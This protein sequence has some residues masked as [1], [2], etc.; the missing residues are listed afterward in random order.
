MSTETKTIWARCGSPRGISAVLLAREIEENWLSTSISAASVRF[1]GDLLNALYDLKDAAKA[2]K[3]NLPTSSLRMALQSTIVGIIYVD[4]DLGCNQK[5]PNTPAIELQTTEITDQNLCDCVASVVHSWAMN[6]LEPWAH[7]EQFGEV[8]ARVKKAAIGSNVTVSASTQYLRDP[9]TRAPN[10]NLIGRLLAEQLS[11]QE[12]FSG[13]DACEMVFPQSPSPNAFE[14]STVPAKPVH[15][16]GG[17]NLYSMIARVHISTMPFNDKVYFSMSCSKRVWASKMP[18]GSNTGDRATA[19]V[20]PPKMNG[21]DFIPVEVIKKKVN[22]V[23]TWD[24]SD[25]YAI[26]V[27]NSQGQLPA[28]LTDALQLG[29]RDPER[30]WVGLPQITR[31]YRSVDQ[32]TAMESDEVD[33]LS[34]ALPMLA[35][36]VGDEVSAIPRRLTLNKKPALTML[37]AGDVGA[38]GI[39]IAEPKEE[40]LST[41]DEND[42]ND[43]SEADSDAKV[44]RF[45]EQCVNVIQQAFLG[46]KPGLW[47]I[48][49]TE[50]E[51]NIAKKT[52]ELLFGDAIAVSI[53]PM[54]SNVHG[55]KT[56]L[57]GAELK[58]KQRF[59][60]RVDAWK[61]NGIPEAIARYP[62]HKF[63]LICAPKDIGKKPE[64]VVNRRAAIHAICSLANASVH[65]V[66][67]I[68]DAN[69]LARKKK[70]VASYIHRIQSAMMDVMLAHSGYVIGASDFVTSQMSDANAPKFICGIQA[71]R[72]Q[73]QRY[74][75]EIPVC[76]V[77]YS[78]INLS[79]NIT[80]VNYAYKVGNQTNLSGWMPLSK[81][82]IW[83][84][85][86]R[87]MD[88]D[89]D[90]LKA[91]FMV[92]TV[93]VLHDIQAQDPRAVVFIDWE[94]MMSLW[95]NLTDASLQANAP[96]IGHLALKNAFPLMSFVRL[97]YGRNAKL[98][99]RS[100]SKTAYEGFRE[101]TGRAPTGEYWDDIYAG[102]IKQ[103]L[104]V[105]TTSTQQGH[106]I[107]VM[108]PRKT[109]QLVRGSS[110]YRFM[111]RMRKIPSGASAGAGIFEK[112]RNPPI[113]KDASV[114]TSMDIT[115]LH[116]PADTSPHDIATL[117]MGLRVGYAHYDDWTLLPA[118]LFFAR[119]IDD[120]IIKYPAPELE[121]AADASL[122]ADGKEIINAR[123]PIEANMDL[124]SSESSIESNELHLVSEQIQRELRLEF[125]EA[126]I[127]NASFD[128]NIQESESLPS[129]AD[130]VST[131]DKSPT[132]DVELDDLSTSIFEDRMGVLGMAKM[133]PPQ[134]IF[135]APDQK[136]RRFYS[137]MV[138]GEIK[139]IVDP[140]YFVE[141]T[142]FFGSYHPSMKK[143]VQKA[144]K[145]MQNFG[146]V[147]PGKPRPVNDRFLDEMAKNL[148]HPQG[149]YSTTQRSFGRFL[150]MPQLNRIVEKHNKEC[151]E[152][153]SLTE[154]MNGNP[155]I[156][157]SPIIKQAC[158][159]NDDETLAWMIFG[160]AQTPSFNFRESVIDNVTTVPGN[161]TYAALVYFVQCSIALTRALLSFN[162][163]GVRKFESI[164][165]KPLFAP[166]VDT[167]DAA[168]AEHAEAI[169]E[170]DGANTST[171][172]AKSI[173]DNQPP[174]EP[175][176]DKV[177]EIKNE[178]KMV[179]DQIKPGDQTF[180]ANLEKV[181]QLIT[182][183]VDIDAKEREALETLARLAT[184]NQDLIDLANRILGRI[185]S[186][187]EECV[188]GTFEFCVPEAENYSDAQNSVTA[189]DVAVS[190]AEASSN[191][192]GEVIAQELPANS[193]KSERI[194]RA[195]Q[196]SALATALSDGL[197]H[198]KKLLDDSLYFVRQDGGSDSPKTDDA[199][200]SQQPPPES[201]ANGAEP[202]APTN[203]P[204]A[205]LLQP[206]ESFAPLPVKAQ[207]APQT[208]A[209]IAS[210]EA[211]IEI[212]LSQPQAQNQPPVQEAI[213]PAQAS[214]LAPPVTTAAVEVPSTPSPAKSSVAVQAAPVAATN[215]KTEQAALT[216]DEKKLEQAYSRL[217]DLMELRHYGLSSVY[218]EAMKA[219]FGKDNIHMQGDILLA[220]AD[221][222]ESIDCRFVVDPRLHPSLRNLFSRQVSF[223]NI[224]DSLG[225]LAA[226]F[227]SA[228]FSSTSISGE[229]DSDALWAVFGPVRPALEGL[230]AVAALIDHVANRLSKGITLTRKSSLCLKSEP[231]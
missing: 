132:E 211:D 94:T 187:D 116:T 61:T 159:Q 29:G 175:Q 76:M 150:I 190:R 3:K 65:H 86:Q 51:Q 10:L 75:G 24:F 152:K 171:P 143:S 166:T 70:A 17:T 11:G 87:A 27:Q 90:W 104:E 52:A 230:P 162:K 225:V 155:Y 170:I 102:T 176:L 48:G 183:L 139:V 223:S 161:M 12:L 146:Y 13:L 135:P 177:M 45:R 195:Q 112:V 40:D 110:C 72:R 126:P 103:L 7:R 108:G 200:E 26:L 30:W 59:S 151:D 191:K 121:A 144:W 137:A 113:D 154:R 196:V 224:S 97:R 38:A 130:E 41:A 156:D 122:G 164:H 179:I 128:E 140:P 141:L 220:L 194:K 186:I 142:G 79:T 20:L 209:P 4:K 216:P 32:H 221:T 53:D 58:S 160:A 210:E 2:S 80:E 107:G 213:A 55:L 227:V 229:S 68:E 114:P 199:E 35:G 157:F 115:V 136:L 212:E 123:V 208:T 148:R 217:K 184:K 206:E 174:N 62:G 201:S 23:W 84:G 21:G 180:A 18:N 49:G 91:E 19:Y 9:E 36:Q 5:Y 185:N 42:E 203:E 6:Q 89:E 182:S 77:I 16:A 178:I 214:N 14:L 158:A 192:L 105:P 120:Y 169:S 8:A 163:N 46:S 168:G 119:K 31:L 100:F 78:R 92:Q 202:P 98:P 93:K 197:E 165:M 198:V 22:D 63:V 147:L 50:D 67:P 138:R 44:E 172:I 218:I 167:A 66:L 28:T 204:A 133:H 37:K 54:P 43:D 205:Q 81:G 96:A 109:F 101:D 47:I 60:A 117:S 56:N 99:V 231:S 219:S 57:P 134:Q 228:L 131:E 71:L 74:S 111:S 82:L 188:I 189:I 145:E 129:V 149:A 222:L 215:A 25:E 181:Q 85:C 153:V 69:T 193:P 83:L 33:L 124:D 173:S 95:R 73:A 226:G 1:S 39:S 127:D 64:D 88:G 106:F 34:T 15:D 118:P 125:I 207:P